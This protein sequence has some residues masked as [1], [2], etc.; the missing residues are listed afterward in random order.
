MRAVIALAFVTAA[1]GSA[2]AQPTAPTAVTVTIAATLPAGSTIGGTGQSNM[3]RALP[4][5][6][7]AIPDGFDVSLS[8]APISDWDEGGQEWASLAPLLN[9]YRLKALVF[10]QGETEAAA[11]MSSSDYFALLDRLM[12]RIRAAQRNPDLRIVVVRII[13]FNPPGYDGEQGY[14]NV[15]NAEEGWVAQDRNARLVNVDDLPQEW[16]NPHLT[17]YTVAVQRMLDATGR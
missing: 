10:W 11:Q 2:H 13:D 17:D 16:F 14:A 6:T 12:A 7:A 15:R 1:C 5:W 4:T 8:G 3:A 9:L